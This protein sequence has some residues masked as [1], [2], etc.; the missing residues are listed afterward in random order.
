MAKLDEVLNAKIVH[1][2]NRKG[3]LAMQKLIRDI[4]LNVQATQPDR[5]PV[6]VFF[7]GDHSGTYP[8]EAQEIIKAVLETSGMIFGMG[9]GKYAFDSRR[10]MMRN[11]QI[12]YLAHYYSQQTGGEYYT[13]PVPKLYP[14]AL[15]YILSQVHL[16]YTLGFKPEVMDGKVHDL[17]LELT[18][19][20]KAQFKDVT[21]RFRQQYLPVAQP[22]A[23]QR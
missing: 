1:G 3:E 19:D 22:D 13:T 10:M 6:M 16:R 21:L 8:S 14:A 12:G 7:Y 4:V 5:L 20:A 18:K 23:G 9:D 2:E 11:G 17:K 15:D